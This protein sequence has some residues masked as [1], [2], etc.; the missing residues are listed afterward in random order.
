MS[1]QELVALTKR[2]LTEEYPAQSF[3]WADK[4]SY[5][6][7]RNLPDAAPAAQAA[8]IPLVVK[9]VP[10][11]APV[12]KAP[13][14]VPA[15]EQK[16]E[17]KVKEVPVPPK[18]QAAATEEKTVY[19]FSAVR[20]ALQET[21]SHLKIIEAIPDDT[22]AKRAAHAWKET[23][24]E[25]IIIADH[26]TQPQ[27]DLLKKICE[28]IVTLGYSSDLLSAPIDWDHLLTAPHLKMIL[29]TQQSLENHPDIKQKYRFDQGRQRHYID[30]ML[31]CPLPSLE[32]LQAE[33]S[34]K[35][36]LWQTIR[37]LLK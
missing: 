23:L 8:P 25:V 34:A 36:T 9:Q 29:M 28:A 31:L 5:D 37:Q 7:F 19:D 30:G 13:P 22:L 32:K 14:P 10:V 15:P 24:P 33:P 3:I 4:E 16:V 18:R 26:A 17:P 2:Y 1:F 21:A 20:A 6:Y 11:S 35:A 27:C 12:I